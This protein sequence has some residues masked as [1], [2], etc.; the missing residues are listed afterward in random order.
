MITNEEKTVILLIEAAFRVKNGK[1]RSPDHHSRDALLVRNGRW[2]TCV[3][4]PRID[5]EVRPEDC[6]E[7]SR[8]DHNL[9]IWQD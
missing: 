9:S 2:G 3:M 5:G 6:E 7:T 4:C 1:P 8:Y